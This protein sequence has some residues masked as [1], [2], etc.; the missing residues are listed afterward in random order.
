MTIRIQI[1]KKDKKLNH[2]KIILF[3]TTK[4]YVVFKKDH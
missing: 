3:L 4:T 1:L 2:H